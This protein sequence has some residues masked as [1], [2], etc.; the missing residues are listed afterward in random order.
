MTT[1]DVRALTRAQLKRSQA[2]SRI[3]AILPRSKNV[4][5]YASLVST[6][7]EMSKKTELLW[8]NFQ[9]ENDDVLDTLIKLDQSLEFST[10]LASDIGEMCATIAAVRRSLA[11]KVLND[12]SSVHTGNLP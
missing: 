11:P 1:R 5:L 2:I 6:F 9:A 3:E 4:T 7:L 12:S 10:V 8:A